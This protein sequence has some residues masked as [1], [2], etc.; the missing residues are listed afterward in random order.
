M[1]LFFGFADNFRGFRVLHSHVDIFVLLE[2][3][4]ELPG[5]RDKKCNSERL[6]PKRHLLDPGQVTDVPPRSVQLH[7]ARVQYLV[8]VRDHHK[9]HRHAD[10]TIVSTVSAQLDRLCGHPE[11][12]LR[13]AVAGTR[14]HDTIIKLDVQSKL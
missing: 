6:L 7:R 14:S 13:H 4:P 12:L 2:N 8:H 5:A 11:L 1:L 3:S 10:H 9:V